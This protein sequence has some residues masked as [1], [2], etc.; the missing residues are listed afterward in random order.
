MIP[1]VIEGAT[2]RLG[3]PD[4]LGPKQ[5][6]ALS[7]RDIPAE[8]GNQQWSKWEFT[9]KERAAVAAGADLYLII[10]GRS[11]PV[12]SVAIGTH[13]EGDPEPEAMP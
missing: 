13:I 4:G 2:R 11:H 3:A 7:I 5:C 8:I 10:Y 1:L 6:A 9:P 12:V